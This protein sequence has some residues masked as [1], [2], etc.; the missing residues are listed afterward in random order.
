MRVWAA[1]SAFAALGTISTEGYSRAEADRLGAL[2]ALRGRK[3]I[4]S[5]SPRDSSAFRHQ[6]AIL[7]PLQMLDFVDVVIPLLR[8]PGDQG[9]Q[10]L[11]Q[12]FACSP[13]EVGH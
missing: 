3:K 2:R 4:S 1:G 5:A 6:V 12:M 9:E 7:S 10:M 8:V 13:A 11:I